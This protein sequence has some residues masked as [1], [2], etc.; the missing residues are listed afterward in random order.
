MSEA[1]QSCISPYIACVV[2]KKKILPFYPQTPMLT[3]GITNLLLSIIRIVFCT[4]CKHLNGAKNRKES[5]RVLPE[6]KKSGRVFFGFFC[7]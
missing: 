6:H 7:S 5:S 2:A 3:L 1:R 4:L